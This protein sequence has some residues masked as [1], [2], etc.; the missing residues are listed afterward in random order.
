MIQG[1]RVD[2]EST[3]SG[4]RRQFARI[5]VA[6]LGVAGFAVVGLS[7]A[8]AHEG[9]GWDDNVVIAPS[10]GFVAPGGM[11]GS[12]WDDNVVFTGISG[13]GGSDD[14]VWHDQWDDD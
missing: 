12:G 4:S 5:A 13:S 2:R 14:P 6:A 10:G 11:G 8:S 7:G 9:H 3:R 1:F